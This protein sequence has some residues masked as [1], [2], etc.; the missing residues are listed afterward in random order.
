MEPARNSRVTSLASC[1]ARIKTAPIKF[2]IPSHKFSNCGTTSDQVRQAAI[3]RRESANFPKCGE[4]GWCGSKRQFPLPAQ[5]GKFADAIRFLGL[6]ETLDSFLLLSHST[7]GFLI[8][9][10]IYTM[11][12]LSRFTASSSP[13]FLHS[14]STLNRTTTFIH[15]RNGRHNP[16]HLPIPLPDP[17][18]IANN[19]HSTFQ[20]LPHNNLD[21]FAVAF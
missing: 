19:A 20:V 11:P 9:V 7:C 6:N 2:T 17:N 4:A 15:Q 16:L 13:S 21:G 10:P 8:L 5:M 1:I 18:T 12:P 14:H 3:G